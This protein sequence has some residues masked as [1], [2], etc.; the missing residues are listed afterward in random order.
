[1]T[2]EAKT[3]DLCHIELQSGLGTLCLSEDDVGIANTVLSKALVV[4]EDTFWR[5][6]SVN[7]RN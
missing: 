6:I 5:M 3:T 1:M 7:G 4:H 2:I